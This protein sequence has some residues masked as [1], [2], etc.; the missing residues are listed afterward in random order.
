MLFPFPLSLYSVVRTKRENFKQLLTLH[1]MGGRGGGERKGGGRKATTQKKQKSFPFFLFFCQNA[2]CKRDK[3]FPLS[4]LFLNC[5]MKGKEERKREETLS[6]FRPPKAT[7]RNLSL[8]GMRSWSPP[9][10]KKQP[11]TQVGWVGIKGWRRR[12]RRKKIYIL[13]DGKRRRR[14]RR[15]KLEAWENATTK[16]DSTKIAKYFYVSHKKIKMWDFFIK[17]TIWALP[18][19]EFW[20]FACEALAPPNSFVCN[21]LSLSVGWRTMKKPNPLSP[22]PPPPLLFLSRR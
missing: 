2:L 6:I 13:R 8:G 1:E 12:R 10:A 9:R 4:S 20:T 22:S 11:T 21:T 15:A 14:R 19:G 17:K 7:D 5:P 3:N 16:W 18:R